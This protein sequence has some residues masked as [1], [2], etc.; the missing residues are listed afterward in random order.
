MSTKDLKALERRV[1]NEFNKGKAATMAVIDETCAPNV[2]YH[3]ATGTNIRGL[4]DF[5]QFFSDLFNAFPDFHMTIDDIVAEGD[6]AVIRY[7]YTGTHKGAF[8]GIPATNKKVTGWTIQI[9]RFVG[10]KCVEAWE[11]MDT[12]GFMQQLGVVPTP[13]KGK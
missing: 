5:K 6:K 12:L 10:G 8:M 3:Q 4:K 7:T 2:V 13:G 9:D 1:A 11:R